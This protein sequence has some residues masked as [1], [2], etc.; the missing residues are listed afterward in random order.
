MALANHNE[1]CRVCKCDFK[2][3]FETTI[4]RPGKY[5]TDLLKICLFHLRYAS[6]KHRRGFLNDFSKCADY[7]I[8]FIPLFLGSIYRYVQKY[9]AVPKPPSLI[10]SDTGSKIKEE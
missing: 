4:E 8:R 1:K 10:A 6:S 5:G 9:F 2:I 7:L 3:K